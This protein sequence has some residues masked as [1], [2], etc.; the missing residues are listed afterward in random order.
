MLVI[1]DNQRVSVSIGGGSVKTHNGFK[2]FCM[3]ERPRG[4]GGGGGLESPKKK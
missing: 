3:N 2:L 4:G 1:M